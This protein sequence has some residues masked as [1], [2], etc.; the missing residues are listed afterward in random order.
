MKKLL[1]NGLAALAMTSTAAMVMT[2]AANA[3]FIAATVSDAGVLR[4]GQDHY[5]EVSVEGDPL[6][7][8]RVQCIT[9]HELDGLEIFVGDKAVEPS[10]NYGFEEFTLTFAEPIPTDETIRIVMKNSRVR[11]TVNAG[12][13]VPYRV[14]GTYPNLGAEV[15]LGTAVIRT[16]G[17]GSR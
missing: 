13:D 6:Q 4:R 5:F 9:F 16:P 12:I 2:P 17:G 10:V 1:L 14:Y 11:G 8:V 7:R 15:P 3:V